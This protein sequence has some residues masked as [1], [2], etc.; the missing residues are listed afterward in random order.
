MRR[1]GLFGLALLALIGAGIL[2]RS[3]QRA[4]TDRPYRAAAAMVALTPAPVLPPAPVHAAAP[5]SSPASSPPAL[6]P[7]AAPPAGLPPLSYREVAALPVHA[8]P[9]D[10]PQPVPRPLRLDAPPPTAARPAAAE[11]S[12]APPPRQ[13]AGRA[14]AVGPATLAIAGERIALYGVRPPPAGERCTGAAGATRPC[15]EQAERALAARLGRDLVCRF[16]RRA[17]GARR[18]ICLDGT[19]VDLGGL[20]VAEGLALADRAG[21]ADYVGAES[22]AQSLKRGLWL[23]R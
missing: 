23:P 20:L 7:A 9:E 12:A 10:P 22:V 15:T 13:L 14:E 11:P 5:P 17:T 2:W 6:V 8:V 1:A 3:Y 16:P 18:A 19:G 21:S 4:Q